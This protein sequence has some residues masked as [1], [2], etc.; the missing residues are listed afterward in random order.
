M[1]HS[2]NVFVIGCGVS[3]L[4]CA[5]LL[6]NKGWNVT[7]IT[8]EHPEQV[9][10]NPEFASLIPAA[11]IIP[12]TLSS[13]IS[14]ELFAGSKAYFKKL[15]EQG[16]PGVKIDEHYE[17]FGHYR[18]VP[19]YATQMDHFESF[20]TFKK[21]FY[22]H[23]P[24]IEILTGWKFDCYFADWSQYFPALLEE[25][26]KSGIDIIVQKLNRDDLTALPSEIIVNC[27]E[28]GAIELFN[29]PHAIIYRGH[30][31]KIPG[32]PTLTNPEGKRVSYNFSPGGD[33]FQSESGFQQD[34]YC[35]SR[36]D[37]WVWGGSRQRGIL[38]DSGSWDIEDNKGETHSIDGHDVP[39]EISQ[40]NKEIIEH[41]F[42]INT[43]EFEPVSTKMGYRY[44][45][46]NQ[47]GLRLEKEKLGDKLIIHNYGHGGAGVTLSWGCA[48]KMVEMLNVEF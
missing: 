31:L 28:I 44:V 13:D 42:G 26:K 17:L 10:K 18:D 32:A 43:A 9:S 23:H 15:H 45:R 38:S 7:I 36:S 21:G 14:E 48:E 3:G 2:K 34:V 41:S 6:H 29:D 11:S 30:I 39:V 19:H 33:I 5:L 27:T 25:V 47:N 24:D 46:K 35:Y 12:H 37:G 8:K 40:L 4:S 22:P 1:K 20:S 16:F